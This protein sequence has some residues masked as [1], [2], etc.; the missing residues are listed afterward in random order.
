METVYFI[1]GLGADERAFSFMD[2]SF[3]NPVFIKWIKPGFNET[4]AAYA[5]RLKEQIPGDHAVIVGLSFG[6]MISVELAKQFAVKK[7][8]LLAS[9]KTGEEIP[10]YLR[11][12]RW[13]PFHK[14]ASPA[15]LRAGNHFA[16]RLMGIHKRADKIV[17]TRMLKEADD[18]FLKW[19]IDRIINWRNRVIPRDTIH[20]HGDKDIMLPK[21]FVKAD[22]T[23]RGGEH[24]MVMN[25]P[26]EIEEILKKVLSSL[27][28]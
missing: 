21:M 18:D 4:I 19:A 23:I 27:V 28:W 20:I 13:L 12:M 10:P 17:F 22:Y 11:V 14:L 6:G 2:L 16:Y 24:L 15:F 26:K 8:I 3:C 25:K 9:A 5:A 1:S 7:I